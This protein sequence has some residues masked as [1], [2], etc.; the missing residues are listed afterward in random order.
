MLGS[1]TWTSIHFSTI[2]NEGAASRCARLSPAT[3]VGWR[4]PT[5]DEAL[6][7]AASG[8]TAWHPVFSN[9]YFD[10]WTST[11]GINP[12]GS[13]PYFTVV[14][15]KDSSVRDDSKDWQNGSLCVRPN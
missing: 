10:V 14:Y 9:Y 15:L 13:Y 11:P 12:Y 5:K 4:L 3:G 8:Y 6:L 7:L 1:Q 2:T